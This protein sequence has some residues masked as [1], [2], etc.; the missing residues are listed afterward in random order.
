[1]F[2]GIMHP[3]SCVLRHLHQHRFRSLQAQPPGYQS[4]EE[5]DP[6]SLRPIGITS[7][8]FKEDCLSAAVG[9]LRLNDQGLRDPA[10]GGLDETNEL[11]RA[12]HAT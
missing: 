7:L 5:F 11:K 12:N 9:P 1:M 3:A 4:R 10:F 8:R 2:G 6:S